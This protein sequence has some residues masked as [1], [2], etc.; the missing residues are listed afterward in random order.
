MKSPRAVRL[1]LAGALLG[2]SLAIPNLPATAQPLDQPDLI[3]SF[4]VGNSPRYLAFDGE[5]IWVTN[6]DD[7]T[8]MK[9][10]PSDGA[11]LGTFT[12]NE[13]PLWIIFDGENIWVCNRNGYSVTKL[14]VDGTVLGTFFTGVGPGGLAW[15]GAN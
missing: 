2:L 8:V 14:A 11:I 7:N 4:P 13:D 15:D 3:Q 10:R 1:A 9:L 12:V 5:N 6:L